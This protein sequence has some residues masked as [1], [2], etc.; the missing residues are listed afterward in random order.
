MSPS[1]CALTSRRRSGKEGV[2]GGP[3]PRGAILALKTSP[4]A[5]LYARHVCLCHLDSVLNFVVI[6]QPVD[7]V[8]AAYGF[9]R[10]SLQLH[11]LY[12]VPLQ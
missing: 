6:V 10:D 8:I 2:P 5:L 1:S 4:R 7:T 12:S 3:R 11:Y 9:L